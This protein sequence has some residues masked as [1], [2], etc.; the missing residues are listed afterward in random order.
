MDVYDNL[1]PLQTIEM[2][3]FEEL[4]CRTAPIRDYNM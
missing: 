4:S 1:K 2:D 3:F